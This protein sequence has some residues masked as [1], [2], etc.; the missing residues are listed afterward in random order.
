MGGGNIFLC[1]D[2]VDSLR[3]Y[4]QHMVDVVVEMN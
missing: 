4:L 3:F 2:G 1:M